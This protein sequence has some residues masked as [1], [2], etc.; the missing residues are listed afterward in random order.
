MVTDKCPIG[1]NRPNRPNRLNPNGPKGLNPNGPK[2]LNRPNG[3]Y[4][5]LIKSLL[6]PDACKVNNSIH[7]TV[8]GCERHILIT[9]MEVHA[10]GEEVRTWKTHEREA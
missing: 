5:S 6:C 10:T 2:G 3:L 1:L 7:R 4:Y 9:A 8:H